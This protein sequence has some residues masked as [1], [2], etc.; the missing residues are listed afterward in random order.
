MGRAFEYRKATKMKRW[1]N[2]ARVFT[3][4]GKQITIAVRE[5]GPEADTN[6][7]L[8]VLIQQSKKENMPKENVERAIKKAISKDE[9]DY[10][11]V[12]Y[13]GYGPFG[14][15]IVVETATDNPTRTVA[16]VRS[17]FNKNNGSLGT[18]GSLEFLFDHKCVFKISP[19]EGVSL[20]DLELELIDYGVDE[21]EQDEEDILLYGEFKSYS[22][23][24]KYLEENGF[25][26]HSAEFERI[27]HELKEVTEEQRAQINKLLDKFEDDEDVQNVFHNMMPEE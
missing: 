7:R 3:K 2:M 24:Q 17:Y 8:R 27:P 23:I 4:L 6:P 22:D 16:N 5:G 20:E 15:A 14:I 25:E 11:E 18:T 9:S 12:T 10:K 19:K 13:E 26:I 21:I 1:G